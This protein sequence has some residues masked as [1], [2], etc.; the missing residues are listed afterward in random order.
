MAVQPGQPRSTSVCCA[1]GDGMPRQRG[2]SN[3]GGLVGP[4]GASICCG[5]LYKAQRGSCSSALPSFPLCLWA[6]SGKR[7]GGASAAG[8]AFSASSLQERRLGGRCS[9]RLG[10]RSEQVRGCGGCAG[11]KA[12]LRLLWLRAARPLTCFPHCCRRQR[13]PPMPC[14]RS[15][16]LTCRHG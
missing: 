16:A 5:L 4:I 13:L 6:R 7:T 2:G 1:A 15:R 12:C 9:R 8:I 10:A 3:Q 14:C 11:A